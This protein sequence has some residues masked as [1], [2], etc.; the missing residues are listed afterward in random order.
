MIER[1]SEHILDLLEAD[2]RLI[3]GGNSF[4]DG[5]PGVMRE[6]EGDTSQLGFVNLFDKCY[7]Q[8]G[9]KHRAAIYVGTHG[10]EATD[11]E[12]FPTCSSGARIEYRALLIPLIICCM[13]P[14]KRESR[15]QRNQLRFN[16]KQILLSNVLADG[17]WYELTVPGQSGGGAAREAVWTTASGGGSQQM[18]ESIGTVPVRVRY[19]WSASSLA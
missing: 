16:V 10:W 1:I 7:D 3:Q 18:A 15:Q 12:D 5:W 17:Y 6:S 13:A 11:S 19:S 8:D 4:A 14:S 9:T 2:S